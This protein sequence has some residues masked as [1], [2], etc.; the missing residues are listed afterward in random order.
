M[1]VE[2]AKEEEGLDEVRQR[3]GDKFRRDGEAEAAALAGA[4]ASKRMRL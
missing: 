4:P 3:T 2:Y 1:V